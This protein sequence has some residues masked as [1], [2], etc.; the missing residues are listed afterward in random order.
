MK[1]SLAIIMLSLL[2]QSF[3]FGFR[4]DTPTQTAPEALVVSLRDAEGSAISDVLVLVRDRSGRAEL[5]RATTD[6]AGIAR[7]ASLP[8][9]EVRVAVQGQLPDGTLLVQ[10]GADARGV[11]CMLGM[12]PTRLD[13][14]ATADGRVGPDPA[15]MITPDLG[16]TGSPPPSQGFP[17]LVPA[18][19]ATTLP[20]TIVP[21]L[22]A[23]T[24]PLPV[25]APSGVANPGIVAALVGLLMIGITLLAFA[26][27]RRGR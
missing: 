8:V 6:A 24:A 18:E 3:G 10:P 4:I 12:P 11:H 5:S 7:F 21:L 26:A 13:L 9:A 14:R 2:G 16:G 23:P 22:V 19:R 1:W 17:T 25:H 15:T 27:V 20:A